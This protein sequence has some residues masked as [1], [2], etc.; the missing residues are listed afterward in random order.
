MQ[1]Q[2][3][4]LHS[5]TF[6]VQ[7]LMCINKCRGGGPRGNLDQ[8]AV[9]GAEKC[10]RWANWWSWGDLNPRP[11]AI[12]EQIYMFSGLFCVSPLP[13]RSHTLRQTPAPLDLVLRKGTLRR[14]SR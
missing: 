11:K 8:E 4:T 6:F 13:A 14:T 12:F 5:M 1:L 10:R 3:P 2:G 7:L 9:R